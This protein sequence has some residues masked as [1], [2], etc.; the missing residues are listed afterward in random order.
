MEKRG[1]AFFDFDGTLIRFDSIV[2]YVF[3]AV[4]KGKIRPKEFFRACFVPIWVALGRISQEQAKTRAMAFSM[5]MKEAER[6]RFNQA[7]AQYLY[8]RCYRD[9]LSE[10]AQCR[11]AG[12]TVVLVSASTDNYMRFV[13]PLFHADALL[14][15]KVTHKGKVLTNCRGQEKVRR[16]QSYLIENGFEA[17]AALTRAYGDTAGDYPMLT[18]FGR[19]V[20]VNPSRALK[21]KAAGHLDERH[22][23]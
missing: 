16:I 8:S 7:F 9:G 11:A 1:F 22:W 2:R 5:R 23:K 20:M 6:V 3:F 21:K 14:C 4:R 18:A 13:A 15:T 12:L 19:G 10:I 17:D